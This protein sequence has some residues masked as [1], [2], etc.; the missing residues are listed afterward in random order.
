MANDP[1]PNGEGNVLEDVRNEVKEPDMWKVSL[2]NDDYTPRDFVVEILV[3]IF[4]KA[5]VEA[6]RI[7]LEVHNTGRGMVGLYPYD[8]GRTKVSQ[9][10]MLA[11]E[12]EFPLKTVL[13][14]A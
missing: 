1:I 6:T 10:T 14:K 2:L 3:S 12:R 8:I 4:R 9:V 5:P 13:E 11:R 7:M